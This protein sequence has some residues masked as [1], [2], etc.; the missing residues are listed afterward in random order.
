MMLSKKLF[1]GFLRRLVLLVLLT[2]PLCAM[3]CTEIVYDT[4]YEATIH[5][6]ATVDSVKVTFSDGVSVLEQ[7]TI[8]PESDSIV[9]MSSQ[10]RTGGFML[11]VGVF[12]TGASDWEYVVPLRFYVDDTTR[13]FNEFLFRKYA[14]LAKA[15]MEISRDI[16]TK[17][18][19][20]AKKFRQ[21]YVRL[22]SQNGERLE[23]AHLQERIRKAADYFNTYL[24][25]HLTG[26]VNRSRNLEIGNKQTLKRYEN[27]FERLVLELRLKCYT[28]AQL[29]HHDFSVN[30]FLHDKALAVL[31]EEEFVK[32]SR[33][34]SRSNTASQKP[35]KKKREPKGTTQRVSLEMFRSGM[36]YNEI[37]AERMLVPSTIFG[38]LRSFVET[39]DLK[40]E[41]III[42]EHITFVKKL[43]EREGTPDNISDYNKLLPKDIC[44]NE[45]YHI[46]KMLLGED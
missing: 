10:E 33:S 34:R 18:P 3:M 1:P 45:Y 19:G 42:Q 22:L 36:N 23:D 39:G 6:A 28:L 30:A 29:A 16:E 46:A 13:V 15:W 7:K 11:T 21:Q 38:H 37:A 40:W 8:G 44:P 12:C 4:G 43:F 32:K 17:L 41:D 5:R 26:L 31:P 24:C 20:V 25:S 2:L 27:S 35:E 9:V 14:D